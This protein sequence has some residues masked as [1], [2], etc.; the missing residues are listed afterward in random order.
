MNYHDDVYDGKPRFVAVVS[1]TIVYRNL[2]VSKTA[3]TVFM[4]YNEY[5]SQ[6]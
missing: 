1:K 4:D 3:V 2:D 5:P 6:F